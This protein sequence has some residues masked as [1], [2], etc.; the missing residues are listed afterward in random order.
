M[1]DPWKIA[2]ENQGLI[3]SYLSKNRWI[4][5]KSHTLEYEDYWQIGLM[6]LRD[7][8]EKHDPLRGIFSSYA[9]K[10]LRWY[11][12]RAW[13]TQGF[14]IMRVTEKKHPKKDCD[15]SA[16]NYQEAFTYN[17]LH[18][19]VDLSATNYMSLVGEPEDSDSDSG[20][21]VFFK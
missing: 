15:L 2:Q 17:V 14:P 12:R 1:T 4:I 20:M 16:M 6:I 3:K 18:S 21:F 7:A 11:M 13:V 10:R 9:M 8:A 19:R 5:D